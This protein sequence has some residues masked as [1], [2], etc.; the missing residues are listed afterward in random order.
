MH[1]APEFSDLLFADGVTDD[2]EPSHEIARL[3]AGSKELYFFWNYSGMSEGD[4]WDALWFI[5]GELAPQAST[6]GETWIYGFSGQAWVAVS[7]EKGL[8]EGL[9]ELA[10]VVNGEMV[11]SASIPVGSASTR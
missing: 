9:Y 8:Q 5:D 3:P 1:S 11:A 6:V 2:G 10:L 7:N 4:T